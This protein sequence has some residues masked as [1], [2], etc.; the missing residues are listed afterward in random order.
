[1]DVCS[2]SSGLPAHY[3]PVNRLTIFRQA[4][5]LQRIQAARPPQDQAFRPHTPPTPSEK[6][7]Y[8]RIDGSPAG[9]DSVPPQIFAAN[10][11][12]PSP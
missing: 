6:P 12:A 5:Q 9:P 2:V 8:W 4:Q 1:M 10:K 7:D 3:R 11:I